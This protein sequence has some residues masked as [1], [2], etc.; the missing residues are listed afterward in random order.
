[1]VTSS[2]ELLGPASDELYY[3]N[4]LK[5]ERGLNGFGSFSLFSALYMAMR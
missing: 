1:M 3:E 5:L 4:Q 2:A